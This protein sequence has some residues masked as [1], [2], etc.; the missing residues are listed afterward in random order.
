M[1]KFSIIIPVYNEID[2][3]DQLVDRLRSLALDNERI[4]VDDG[5][6]DGSRE[7]LQELGLVQNFDERVLFHERNQGR[8]AAIR[9][10]IEVANGDVVGPIDADLEYDPQ[11]LLRVAQVVLRGEADAAHGSRFL[12]GELASMSRLHYFGNRFIT[13]V[14]RLLYRQRLTDL[15]TCVKVWRTEL[16]KGLDLSSSGFELEAEVTAK[17]FRSGVTIRELP[18]DYYVRQY[19]EKKLT[20]RDG[21]P[22]VA[23]LL[24][25][26]WF[27]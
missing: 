25:Y 1:T 22:M 4:F 7:F 27:S 9:H 13:A 6:T 8:G 15:A 2:T 5:S 10:G 12:E 24:K 3:L 14:C 26:R 16:V 19:G 23:T 18:I 11:D 17:L 21:F 20:W